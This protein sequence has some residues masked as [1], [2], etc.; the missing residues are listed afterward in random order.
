MAIQLLPG[1]YRVSEGGEYGQLNE[2]PSKTYALD[3]TGS[4]KHVYNRKE[5]VVDGQEAMRQAIFKLLATF[6]GWHDIYNAQY[7]FEME[8]IIGEKREVA[9]GRVAQRIEA[10]LRSDSRILSVDA[11]HFQTAK[12]VRGIFEVEIHVSTR[13]G[14]I[15]YGSTIYPWSGKERAYG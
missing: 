3:I 6:R 2:Q 9:L 14:P 4:E 13:F 7:G 10:A 8:G 1:S 5:H 15:E 12:T 11:I